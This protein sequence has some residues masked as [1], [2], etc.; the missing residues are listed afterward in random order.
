MELGG[1]LKLSSCLITM[2]RCQ[3]HQRDGDT[4][5]AKPLNHCQQLL[6]SIHLIVRGVKC[7]S[8]YKL[9]YLSIEASLQDIANVPGKTLESKL[10]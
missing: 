3:E 1:N 7:S 10:F 2:K 4:N 9:S 8:S 6:I 5:M